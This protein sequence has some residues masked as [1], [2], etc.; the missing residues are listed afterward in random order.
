MINNHKFYKK[1]IKKYGISAQG[2][3][4]N[5][6]YTQYKRFQIITQC[7][8]N[9]RSST[10]VDA[11]CGFGEYYKYLQN[12]NKLP[13]S[14]IGVDIESMM[15]DVA[16]KRFKDVSFYKT[17][18]LKDKLIIADYYICSGSMNIL[19][20]TDVFRFI[21]RSFE[22]S[23]KGFIFNFLTKY[24]FNKLSLDEVKDFCTTLSSKIKI[25]SNYLDNDITIALL[26]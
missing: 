18:I 20:K 10:I 7:I 12:N 13:S 16:S 4:W 26:K 9:I 8:D 17:D 24:S 25:K 2:V 22:V 11:G 15:I 5:N 23:Q 21:Q 1:S 6:K 14:Y 3:H 19:N